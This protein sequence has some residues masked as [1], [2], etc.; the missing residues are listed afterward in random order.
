MIRRHHL[1]STLRISKDF[2]TRYIHS[3]FHFHYLNIVEVTKEGGGGTAP[4]RFRP[5]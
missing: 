5:E 2:W 4:A 1:L 3:K